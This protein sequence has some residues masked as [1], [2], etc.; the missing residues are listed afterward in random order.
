MKRLRRGNRADAKST[1]WMGA[2]LNLL[3]GDRRGLVVALAFLSVISSLAEGLTLS[4]FALV[5]VSL[6]GNKHHLTRS[7]LHVDASIGLLI[8]IALGLVLFRAVLQLPLSKLPSRIA[9]DVQSGLR[10][11]LFHAFTRAS[12]G[13]QSSDREGQLQETMSGQVMQATSG[14]LQATS[15]ITTSI[16]FVVLMSFAIVLNSVAAAGV[17][18]AAIVMFAALRPLR[19]IAVRRSRALSQ[20]QVRYA[21]GLAEANRMAEETQVF[22]VGTAQRARMDGLIETSRE[23]FYKSQVVGRLVP[24]MYQTLIYLVLVAALAAL[25]AA[26]TGHAASLGAVVLILLRASNSGQAVQA[27]YQGLSQSMPFIERT[28]DAAERYIASSPVD[29]ETP[30]EKIRTIEFEHVDFSYRP[31]TPTLT[32]ISFSVTENEAIGV[33]GPSGAG[34]STLIQL[35]LQLRFPERG[36]YLVNGAPVGEFERADWHRLVSYVPQTPKLLHASVAENIRYLRDIDDEQVERAAKLARIH[37]EVMSWSHG[38][39]TIVGP[40]A[41]AVSG[42]QQQRICLARALAARPE[43][44]ILDEPTSA[45]DPHS[46]TLIQES[47][48]ALRSNLT[49][50]II[51]HRMSTLDICDRVMIIQEGRLAA[52]DSRVLLQQQNQYYRSAS[53]IAAGVPGGVLP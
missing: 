16:N 13:T 31:G 29:G 17:F 49:M 36:R 12:W 35:L 48:T 51:A 44:L 21:A 22:G 50:F 30:L 32:D 7:L 46:E 8:L 14:A 26:G 33:I 3:I 47:L 18:V 28:Q 40:R 42:G 25:D 20:A 1:P 10:R 38:Y 2:R 37:D 53:M 11:R 39:E 34:K 27:S 15:L 43:V 9:G 23:L 19:K 6:T 52:F 24:S 5:A 41:D 4:I 45:L